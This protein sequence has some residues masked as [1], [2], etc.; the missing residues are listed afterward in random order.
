MAR[1]IAVAATILLSWR[2]DGKDLVP[3]HAVALAP[4]LMTTSWTD[5]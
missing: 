5:C 1:L 3:D 4:H 2:S